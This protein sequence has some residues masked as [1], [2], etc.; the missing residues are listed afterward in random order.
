[1]I[2]KLL[3]A[4]QQSKD[5]IVEARKIRSDTL[6]QASGEADVKLGMYE[7][8]LIGKFEIEEGFRKNQQSTVNY[9]VRKLKEDAKKAKAPGSE[10]SAAFDQMIAAARKCGLPWV[11]DR[12]M[13]AA[14]AA[15]TADE[16][17]KGVNIAEM[18]SI[19]AKGDIGKFDAVLLRGSKMG[20]PSGPSDDPQVIA[21]IKK[22]VQD[23]Y[24]NNKQST[25]NYIKLKVMDVQTTLSDTQIQ[26]L[27]TG[28]V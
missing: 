22:E 21:A 1:M 6:K 16:E 5:V 8:E 24:K 3:E 7:D 18:L 15:A 17:L 12:M 23:K 2:K 10:E 4:E 14:K 11:T 28:V 26:S 25:V 27:K 13:A 9:I 20:T 19:Y